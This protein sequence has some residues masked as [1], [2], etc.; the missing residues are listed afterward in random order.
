[1]QSPMKIEG[2]NIGKKYRRQWVF[3]DQTLC[4]EQGTSW[5]IKGH[6]GAG[7]STLMAILS[8][9]LSPSKGSIRYS[10]EGKKLGIDEVYKQLSFAAPYI[11]LI[12][13]FTLQE[14]VQFHHRFKPLYPDVSAN[15]LLELAWLQDSRNKQIKQLSSGMKQR[16]K[17]A[18]ALCSESSLLLLDEPTTNLDEQGSLWYQQLIETYTR[19]RTLLIASN[20]PSDHSFCSHTLVLGTENK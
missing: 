20:I 3:K 15:N 8:G 19:H 14:A 18:L 11:D 7:K 6:N 16:F 1:M 2:E 4:F 10:I 17:L 13:D 9:Y 5:A 12:E